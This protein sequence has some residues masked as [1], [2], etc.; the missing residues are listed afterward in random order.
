MHEKCKLFKKWGY[1]GLTYTWEQKPLK[2][3]GGKW[4]KVLDWID[5]E[6]KW[7]K[8]EKTIW[9]SEEH[10]G[11]KSLLFFFSFK[12]WSVKYRLGTNRTRQKV[13]L[14]KYLKFWSVE[15]WFHSIE[16]LI[17]LIEYQSNQAETKLKN[18]RDFQLVEKHIWSIEIMENWI[19]W[20][21]AEIFAKNTQ[22]K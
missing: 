22:T 7:R 9:K 6:R 5:R 13:F 10:V 17:Q 14:K 2:I 3:W 20:K 18:W 21:I 4:Q 15:K 8:R 16:K 12:S 19:F 1:L 11:W